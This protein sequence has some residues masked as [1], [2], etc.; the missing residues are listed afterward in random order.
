MNSNFFDSFLNPQHPN[1]WFLPSNVPIIIYWGV[2][3]TPHLLIQIGYQLCKYFL[4]RYFTY[5]VLEMFNWLNSNSFFRN[6][7]FR[8]SNFLKVI[9]IFKIKS[10]EN[11]FNKETF[12]KLPTCIVDK[13]FGERCYSDYWKPKNLTLLK[14]SLDGNLFGQ[15]IAKSVITSALSRQVIL[16]YYIQY[17]L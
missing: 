5:S 8:P 7:H 2:I 1:I 10:F 11:P 4:Q 15:H 12:W 17:F 3:W 13:V 16:I 6:A 9:K 14:S